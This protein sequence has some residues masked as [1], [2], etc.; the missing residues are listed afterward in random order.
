MTKPSV[1][2]L[3][4]V[5]VKFRKIL[6]RFYENVQ[7]SVSGI[8]LEGC[9]SKCHLLIGREAEAAVT[10]TEGHPGI[11]VALRPAEHSV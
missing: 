9:V 2:C 1:F 7:G 8:S 5:G 4:D 11:P 10:Q 6:C 3:T